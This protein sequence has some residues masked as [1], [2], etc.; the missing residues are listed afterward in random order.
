MPTPYPH[1]VS[2]T[3]SYTVSNSTSRSKP[4]SCVLLLL[5]IAVLPV[6]DLFAQRIT[7]EYLRM[8]D[9]QPNV[10]F[11][12][13][14]FPDTSAS[15]MN[16]VTTFRI[17]N[18]FLSFRRVREEAD[19]MQARRFFSEPT[20]QLSIQKITGNPSG[21][22]SPESPRVQT[23]TW[24]QTIYT[25]TYEQTQSSTLFV[26]DMIIT[27][28][29]SGRYQIESTAR[30]DSR[31][32][33]SRTP[34]LHIPEKSNADKAFFYFLDE[35]SQIS[36]P[37]SNPLMNMGNNVFFGRD[38]SVLMWIPTVHDGASYS[39]DITKLRISRQDTIRVDQVFEYHLEQEKFLTGYAPKISMTD[40]KPHFQLEASGSS[41]V[42]GAF[43]MITIP[44]SR[45]ENAYYRMNLLRKDN[46]NESVTMATKSYQS[47][48]LDMPVSLL[49]LDVAINM[50]RFIIG[51]SQLRALRRGDRQQRER[52]FRDFWAQRDPTP[53]REYNEL[54]VEYF[55]RIDY[56]FE[57]F[58]TPQNPGYESDQG[59]VY[60]RNGEPDRRERTFPPNQPARETWYYEGQRFLFEAT[61]GFGDFKLVDQQ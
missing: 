16:L 46:P 54:M 30:S 33:R 48:W 51:D 59:K 31:S 15:A 42:S 14:V 2:N 57:H 38:F 26:E 41:R 3:P 29:E 52:Q 50:M 20:V 49:N 25:E 28:L 13:L 56:A 47:L 27:S 36:P 1:T 8:R 18:N 60:I 55:R 22:V 5:L 19:G 23:R 61:T 17:D 34:L 12:H 4:V 53:E 43:Y 58:T 24:N 6:T 10:F 32:R 7:Y 21:N 39:L 37:F 40:G 45:F 35:T 44:N 11:E 9:R